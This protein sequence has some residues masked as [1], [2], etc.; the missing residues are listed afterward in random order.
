ML[1]ESSLT[2][3]L[4]CPLCPSSAVCS[5]LIYSFNKELLSACCVPGSGPA[6]GLALNKTGNKPPS[7]LPLWG[8]WSTRIQTQTGHMRKTT[9]MLEGEDCCGGEQSRVGDWVLASEG[10]GVEMLNS[11]VWGGLTEGI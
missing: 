3:A 6:G 11:V 10:R 9:G 2:F 7:I 8:L 5:H 1:P 4:L